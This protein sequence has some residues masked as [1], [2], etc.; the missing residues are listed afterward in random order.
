MKN[1]WIQELFPNLFKKQEKEEPPKK[2]SDDFIGEYLQ[3]KKSNGE[4]LNAKD[5]FAQDALDGIAVGKLQDALKKTLGCDNVDP[6]ANAICNDWNDAIKCVSISV[7]VFDCLEE[8]IMINLVV[9]GDTDTTDWV[10][11][12]I[13]ETNE[14][15]ATLN[16]DSYPDDAVDSNFIYDNA[17][18]KVMDFVLT[19]MI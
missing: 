19:K 14:P 15:D 11:V 4:K 16:L 3:S 17:A 12:W 13:G 6:C 10:D 18:Q 5:Y 1:K 8:A 2:T 9:D 7:N